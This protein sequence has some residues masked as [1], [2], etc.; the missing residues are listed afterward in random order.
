MIKYGL[1][2]KVATTI[3]DD[4]GWR[5]LLLNEITRRTFSTLSSLFAF[6]A[7]LKRSNV[8]DTRVVE[9]QDDDPTYSV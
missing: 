7:I 6:E 3:R 2:I 5:P 8:L 1:D 4:D 9:V